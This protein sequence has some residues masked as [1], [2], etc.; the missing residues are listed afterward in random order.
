MALR[1]GQR[2]PKGTRIGSGKRSKYGA[3]PT[4]I[5]GIRFAS[6]AEAK[7]YRELKLL[8]KAGEV[9]NIVLQPRF[10]LYVLNSTVRARLQR[11][12]ARIREQPDPVA[13]VKVGTYVADFKYE[14]KGLSASENGR[15]DRVVEDV[16]GFSTPLYKWKKRHVEAQYNIQI[17]EIR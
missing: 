5:D 12:A 13:P 3:I 9:R 2:L 10:D 7:R 1:Q 4:V 8:E 6:K 15:W 17:Q 14:R 11:I 16:K